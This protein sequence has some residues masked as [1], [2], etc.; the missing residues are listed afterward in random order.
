[1]SHLWIISKSLIKSCWCN[2]LNFSHLAA[3]LHFCHY[4]VQCGRPGFDPWVGKIPRSRDRLPTSVFEPGGF[5]GLYSPWGHKESDMTEQLSLLVYII[6][7]ASGLDSLNSTTS[8]LPLPMLQLEI[9][10]FSFW[11][12]LLFLCKCLSE[13]SSPEVHPFITFLA[14]RPQCKQLCF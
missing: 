5:H 11:K 1:M 3:S 14:F 13:H 10:C 6:P 12:T 9:T 2:P 4:H 7:A 8:S